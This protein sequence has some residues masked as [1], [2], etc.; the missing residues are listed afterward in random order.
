MY[1]DL[2][3]FLRKD[4]LPSLLVDLKKQSR[5][6]SHGFLASVGRAIY[7]FSLDSVSVSP[8]SSNI[9]LLWV[10]GS[11]RAGIVNFALPE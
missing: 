2:V 10:S 7:Y 11:K 1:Q 3:L 4:Q 6:E 5:L 8:V 9:E